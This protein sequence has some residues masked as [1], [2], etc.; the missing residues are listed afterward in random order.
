MN[1]FG[2]NR[3]LSSQ[4]PWSSNP[5]I[6]VAYNFKVVLFIFLKSEPSES[7]AQITN[8]MQLMRHRKS[9]GDCGGG[10]DSHSPKF[11]MCQTMTTWTLIK[12]LKNILS[13]K[14]L[15]FSF[16]VEAE[17]WS[18]LSADCW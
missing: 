16:S 8:K 11:G 14:L 13:K 4:T 1:L 2:N 17:M 7:L 10:G 6:I 5:Q 15:K 12:Q 9:G 18:F 3:S